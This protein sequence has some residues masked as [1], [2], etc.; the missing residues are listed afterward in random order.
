MPPPL[1]RRKSSKQLL[2]EKQIKR[3]LR[4]KKRS[5]NRGAKKRE[6]NDGGLSD[7][8]I[9]DPSKSEADIKENLEVETDGIEER[10]REARWVEYKITEIV[11]TETKVTYVKVPKQFLENKKLTSRLTSS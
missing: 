10:R 6:E 2:E 5:R 7:D 9:T 3:Y 1:E 8:K 11:T 4:S